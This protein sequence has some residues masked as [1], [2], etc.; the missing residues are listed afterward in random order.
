MKT[1]FSLISLIFAGAVVATAQ[2]TVRGII[3]SG[4]AL[5]NNG[6]VVTMGQPFVGMARADDNSVLLSL[7][8]IPTLGPRTNSTTAF[9][10]SPS[11]TLRNGRFK[12]SFLAGP[13]RNWI[14]LGSTNLT[15]WEP[16]W[17]GTASEPLVE[18]EDTTTFFYSRRFYRVW[19]P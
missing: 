2:G 7:G 15:S 12:F 10:I 18:F 16:V 5:L 11:L 17:S 9:T 14:V 8:L 13:G 4:A 3:C 19:L 1:R 6:G